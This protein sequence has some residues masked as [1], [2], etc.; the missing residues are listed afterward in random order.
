MADRSIKYRLG[1]LEDI[2]IKVGD[3]Y[4]PIDFVIF[5]MAEYARTQI[6]LGRPLLATR[7]CKI[8]VKEGK[9]TFDVGGSMLSLACSKIE[10][11]LP[12]LF[13]VLDVKR[14]FFMSM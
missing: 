7:G 13:L 9:L 5:E 6:I 14:L 4:V 10:N 12:L 1:T 8:D 3:F 11:L 2:P